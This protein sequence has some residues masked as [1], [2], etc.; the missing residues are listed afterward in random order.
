LLAGADAGPHHSAAL[1]ATHGTVCRY[2]ADR[3]LT[4]I[5]AIRDGSAN[6]IDEEPELAERFVVRSIPTVVLAAH[7]REL[8]RLAGTRP[9]AELV[10][11]ARAHAVR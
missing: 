9:A 4:Q 5:N 11:W 2:E 6:N 3:G 7:G 8:G 1:G 10:R